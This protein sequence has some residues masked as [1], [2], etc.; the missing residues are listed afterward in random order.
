MQAYEGGRKIEFR[1]K[2]R[3]LWLPTVKPGWNWEDCEYRVK[4]EFPELPKG[5]VWHNPDN[6]PLEDFGDGFRPLLPEEVDGRH[7]GNKNLYVWRLAAKTW[8]NSGLLGNIDTVTYRITTDVPIPQD[9]TWVP[10]TF[11][12]RPQGA[13]SIRKKKVKESILISKWDEN[14]VYFFDG[15][16]LGYHLLFDGWEQ[17]DGNPCGTKV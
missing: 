7:W 4:V 11:E 8:N 12:T 1:A 15:G 3:L 2:S 16:R 5:K 13:V 9:P 6:V 14:N 10:W 17:V